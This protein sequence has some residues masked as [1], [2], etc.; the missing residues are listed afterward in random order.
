MRRDQIKEKE[1]NMYLKHSRGSLPYS[2][3][4]ASFQSGDESKD[5]SPGM[6]IENKFLFRQS[7]EG[8]RDSFLYENTSRGK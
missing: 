7:D 3:L 1:P 8:K 4:K 2:I 6:H 5:E